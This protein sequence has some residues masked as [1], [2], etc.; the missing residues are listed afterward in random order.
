MDGK[1]CLITGGSDGIGYAAARELARMGA[2][3]VIAGR[4]ATKTAAAAARIVE[5]TGNRSVSAP[6]PEASP[7]A[8]ATGRPTTAAVM[9]PNRSPLNERRSSCIPRL[10]DYALDASWLRQAVSRS[11]LRYILD[12][13]GLPCRWYT[14]GA[15]KARWQRAPQSA[16]GVARFLRPPPVAFRRRLGW[17]NTSLQLGDGWGGLLTQSGH[18][19]SL[20]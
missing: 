17:A 7:K 5:E 10:P 4:N 3:V 9:P 11:P 16:G 8:N 6:R 14:P 1:S 18:C 13:I 19:L 20:Q 2:T 15:T 12:H